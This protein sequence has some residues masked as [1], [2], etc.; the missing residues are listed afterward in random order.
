ML[1]LAPGSLYAQTADVIKASGGTNLSIDSVATQGFTT[2]DGPIIRE[3]AAGQLAQ[4]GTIVL[5]LP[6]GFVWND[7]LTGADITIT[8]APTGAANT[9]LQVSFTSIT[10]S[11]VTFT[12]DTESSTRGNGQG[13]GRVEIQGLQLRPNTTNV[14]TTGQISNTG[15][16]GPDKN[17]GDLSTDVGA[18]NEVIV[19]DAADGSGQVLQSRDIL[20]GESVTGYAIG[21]DVGNN[22][23][24]NVALASEADWTL[25]NVSGNVQQTAL[26]P[27]TDL[28]SATFSSDKTGSAQIQVSYSGAGTTPSQ[29][30]T[31]L[32]RSTDRMVINTQPSSTATAGSAFPTQPV[33]FLQ[34]QFGNKVTTDNTTQVTA[35]INT[36]E[37]SLSGTL[38]QTASNGE[39]SFTDLYTTTA[40]TITLRFESSGLS[41]L[42]SSQVIVNPAAASGLSYIQQPT[43]T[44]QNGTISPPVT[45]QLLDQYGNKVSTGGT[46]VTIDDESFLKSGSTR[47]AQTDANGVAS[48]NNLSITSTATL[49]EVQLTARFTGISAPVLSD[50]FLII[51]ADQL[52]GYDITAPDGSDI[53]QQQ[54]GT[55]FPI[56]ITARD[57]NGDVKTD[58]TGTV[59]VTA[60][61]TIQINGT[62]VSSF[63][64]DNFQSGVL[65]TA[66][67][68][69]SSGSTK[70]YADQGQ[71]IAGESNS[72]TVT[73]SG[74]IDPTLSTITANPT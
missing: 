34:D 2:I 74:T 33:I 25:I 56:R 48:F 6:G 35:S 42:T 18:I 59:E 1:Y 5:T 68:L 62:T 28:K 36:G 17:Y 73:P 11:E 39:V 22:F 19:E 45:L 47:S 15:T 46:T 27:S 49:G 31:V 63:T 52:A 4:N 21:R 44:A 41:G 30:I 24:Q 71:D 13:P 12:V 43:N 16:T 7:A 66:V 67:T 29:T 10:Q 65:D 70:I 40:D 9:Q 55:E 72:F 23:V 3:T 38:T 50:P 57:G 14:P 8:I 32:P 69:I 54:A 37:G 20:A 53:T 64:T 60:D 61:A 26:T 51:S 58:F